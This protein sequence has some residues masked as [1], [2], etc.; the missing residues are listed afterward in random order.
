MALFLTIMIPAQL[1]NAFLSPHYPRWGRHDN[2][3]YMS[4][5]STFLHRICLPLMKL[6]LKIM[7][8]LSPHYPRWGRHVTTLH[9]LLA[10]TFLHRICLPPMKLSLKIMIPPHI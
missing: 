6:S 2:T 3:L 1:L 5:P 4:L 7:I 8:L 10:S 9:M